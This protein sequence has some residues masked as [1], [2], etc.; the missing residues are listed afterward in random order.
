MGTFRVIHYCDIPKDWRGNVV[1]VRVVCEVYPRKAEPNYT[2]I[3]ME[4]GKTVV[5]FD[6]GILTADLNLVKLMLNSIL[7]RP[8]AKFAFSDAGIFYW[9]TPMAFPEYICINMPTFPSDAGISTS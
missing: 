5:D 6:I 7:S 4:G 1:F 9:Q 3:T 8:G 2:R